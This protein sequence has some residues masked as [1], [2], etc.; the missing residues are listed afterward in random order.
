M[1]TLVSL[2]VR[3]KS[4]IAQIECVDFTETFSSTGK[5]TTI[6]RLIQIA[7]LQT[8]VLM[9]VNQLNIMTAYLNAPLDCQVYL[10]KHQISV[11]FPGFLV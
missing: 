7:L 8:K 2:S 10:L 5:M 4:Q 6:R 3:K 1:F 11:K 9:Y